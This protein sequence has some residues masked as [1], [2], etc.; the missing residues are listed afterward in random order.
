MTAA[1]LLQLIIHV[2]RGKGGALK[3]RLRNKKQMITMKLIS[4][5]SPVLN[6]RKQ[7]NC[8]RQIGSQ[9]F[10]IKMIICKGLGYAAAYLS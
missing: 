10:M 2:L 5:F 1:A 4:F 7:I 8:E 3:N 9:P 6:V